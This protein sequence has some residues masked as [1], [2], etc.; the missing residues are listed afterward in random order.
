MVSKKNNTDRQVNELENLLGAMLAP[1]APRGDF[2][3]QLEKQL[4]SKFDPQSLLIIPTKTIN[5]IFFS[6]VGLISGIV[7]TM[8]GIKWLKRNKLDA[9]LGR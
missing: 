5:I 2:V 7:I 6:I 8:L 4:E 1:V 9:K 3:H